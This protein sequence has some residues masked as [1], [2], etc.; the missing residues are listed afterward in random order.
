MGYTIIIGQLDP[1]LEPDEYPIQITEDID[2]PIFEPDKATNNTNVRKVMYSE[3]E[4][5]TRN[6]GLYDLFFDPQTGL[7][8]DHPGFKNLTHDHLRQVN[9][10][11]L[12]FETFGEFTGD[13]SMDYVRLVWLRFWI[14]W[15]LDNATDPVIYN[16]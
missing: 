1:T 16:S 13:R 4:Q 6:V 9:E 3:W 8:S 11:Y 15:A 12:L 7:I 2:A 14:K 10:A 5:F